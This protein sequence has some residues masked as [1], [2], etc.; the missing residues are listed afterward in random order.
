MKQLSSI[1]GSVTL[2][3]AALCASQAHASGQFAPNTPNYLGDATHGT[4][5]GII[6]PNFLPPEHPLIGNT[7]LAPDASFTDFWVVDIIPKGNLVVSLNFLNM[8][9]IFT[10]FSVNLFQDQAPITNLALAK[11]TCASQS[12]ATGA[13]A[14]SNT[15]P[16]F[17]FPVPTANV[18]FGIGSSAGFAGFSTNVLLTAGRYVFKVSGTTVGGNP[19]IPPSSTT[20]AGP[21]PSY[22]GSIQVNQ[23][24]EP[25]TLALAALAMLGVVASLGRRKAV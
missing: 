11:Y 13:V 23:I 9:G 12:Q 25:G 3:V 22:S 4:Y 21:N 2:A 10:A 6:D 20:A 1:L 8:G 14:C 19:I 24:P 7:S 5:I 16:G 15:G 18:E 17:P